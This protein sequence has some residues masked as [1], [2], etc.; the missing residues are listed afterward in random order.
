MSNSHPGAA[1]RPVKA[2][3]CR[4]FATDGKCFFGDSCQ[5]V[6]AK[7]GAGSSQTGELVYLPLLGLLVCFITQ[8]GLGLINKLN[9]CMFVC[10]VIHI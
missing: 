1:N 10:S 3:L 5:F 6:H 7:P 2:T 8:I 9:Q 4:Y